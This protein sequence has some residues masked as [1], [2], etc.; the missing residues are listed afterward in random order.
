MASW[1]LPTMETH[2]KGKCKKGKVGSEESAPKVQRL[3]EE[4]STTKKAGASA[5]SASPG[6]AVLFVKDSAESELLV[7]SAVCDLMQ[8]PRETK[9]CCSDFILMDASLE[10]AEAG[11]AVNRQYDVVVKK[12][13]AEGEQ[14]QQKDAKY[15]K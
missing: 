14:K 1:L 3:G 2:K 5:G 6:S 13:Q 10:A 12:F 9:A 11:L 7:S 8:G 15:V 4:T